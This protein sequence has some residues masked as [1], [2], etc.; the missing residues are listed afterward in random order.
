MY[1]CVDTYIYYPY[2]YIYLRKIFI[3]RFLL[4]GQMIPFHIKQFTGVCAFVVCN[5]QNFRHSSNMKCTVFHCISSVTP[6]NHFC[7][8]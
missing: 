8:S 4:V 1:M 7:L 5:G 6:Q 3:T 2:V